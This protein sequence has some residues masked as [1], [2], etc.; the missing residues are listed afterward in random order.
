MMLEMM[1]REFERH[2]LRTFLTM[3]GVLIGIFL[4]TSVSS[5]SEGIS[6]YINDRIAITSGLVTVSERGLQQF[7]MMSSEIDE[8]LVEDVETISGVEEVSPV[9]FATIDGVSLTG[10]DP[11]REEIIR[12]ITIGIEDGTEYTEG[13]KEI[14]AGY[15]FARKNDYNVGYTIKL[16]EDEYEIV[17]ILQESGDSDIDNAAMMPLSDL[18]E[19]AG[20]EGMISMMMVKPLTPADADF[21]EQTINDEFDD[22]TA[23]TDKSIQKSVNSML[24]Q[25]SIMTFALGSIAALISGIVIMNVMIIAVRERRREIGTMKAVGATNRQILT[26]ILVESV[27]ISVG[28]AILGIILSYGGAAYLN[29]IL[30][31]PVAIIT[32]RLVL[33]GILFA[34]FIGMVSGLAPARQAAKLSPIEALRYE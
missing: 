14:V 27:T 2:K 22:L 7:Q 10:I 1:F 33:Q 24:D 18:Q 21:I 31:R 16:D 20:K 28:G 3:L 4:V 9:L 15:E 6:Y 32:P 29:T 19:L 34:G 30:L 12:G 23:A 11:E 26:A 8:D 17:G 25:M 5:F 13:A